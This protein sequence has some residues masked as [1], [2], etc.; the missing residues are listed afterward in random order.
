MRIRPLLFYPLI[1]RG[2]ATERQRLIHQ[3]ASLTH[4]H[5][6]STLAGFIYLKLTDATLQGMD[7]K[8]AY[9]HIRAIISASPNDDLAPVLNYFIRVLNGGLH[10]LPEAAIESSGYAA[11]ALEAAILAPASLLWVSFHC[12]GGGQLGQ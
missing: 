7:K 12:F 1:Q 11:R 4:R 9:T 6:R 10:L 5:P 8:V 2:S 3:V